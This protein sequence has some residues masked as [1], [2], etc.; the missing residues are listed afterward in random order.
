[1]GNLSQKSRYGSSGNRQFAIWSAD[2]CPLR[3]ATARSAENG[4]GAFGVVGD[5]AG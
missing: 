1:M 4:P 2:F 5:E 3:L